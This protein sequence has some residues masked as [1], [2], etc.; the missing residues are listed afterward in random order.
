MEERQRKLLIDRLVEHGYIKSEKV[1]KALLSVPRELFV[2]D[3]LRDYAYADTPLE[4]G[5]GQTISAPHMVAIMC[6][7]LDLKE[8]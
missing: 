6:E 1:K 4:I 3:D 5:N 8:G 2:S 7:T